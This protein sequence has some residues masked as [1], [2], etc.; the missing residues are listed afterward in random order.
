MRKKR[1][2]LLHLLQPVRRAL[3]GQLLSA[4][5]GTMAR[6]HARVAV[7]LLCGCLA[8]AVNAEAPDTRFQFDIPPLKVQL[9]LGVLAKQSG[10]QLLFSHKLVDSHKSSAVVGEFSVEGALQRLLK[11]TVLSGRVTERGVIVVSGGASK[12]NDGEIGKMNTKR[13]ILAM[14]VGGVLSGGAVGQETADREEVE[15]LLEEI[16]VTAAK[17][18]TALKNSAVAISVLSTDTIDKR[19][20]VTMNDYLATVPGASYIER[21][22]T[23]KRVILRGLST[24]PNDIQTVAGVYLG[25]QPLSSALDTFNINLV[26]IER[27]EVVKGPQGTLYGSSALGGVVRNIPKKVN[28]QNIEG[29]VKVD[30]SSQG[31]SDDYNHSLS[32]VVNVPIVE[33]TLGMRVVAYRAE[34]AGYVDIVAT[35]EAEGIALITGAD[36]I[37]KKDSN[38]STVDGFRTSFLWQPSDT[39]RASLTLGQQ[40]DDIDGSSNEILDENDYEVSYLN[41]EPAESVD[42]RYGNLLI[43]YDLGW[44][45][46]LSSS[47]VSN[48]E[49]SLVR[50]FFSTNADIF[51]GP[52]VAQGDKESDLKSQELRFNSN[53]D[54]AWQ[55]LGGVFYEEAELETK[56]ITSWVG[57]GMPNPFGLLGLPLNPLRPELLG[58]QLILV[59]YSQLAFFGEASYQINDQWLLTVGGRHFDYDREDTETFFNDAPFNTAPSN[60][61]VTNDISESGE[62]YKLNLAY[63]PSDDALIYAQWS[64]GF[65]LGRG[66]KLPPASLCDTDN[67]GELDFNT[68]GKITPRVESDTS[69]QLE[70]GVKLSLMEKRMEL[71]A[72]IFH[73]D[74][75]NLPIIID[76]DSPSCPVELGRITNNIGSASTQGIE[77]DMRYVLDAWLL[78]MSAS[79]LETEREDVRPPLFEGEPLVYAPKSNASIGLQYNFTVSG[80]DAFART[81]VSYVGEYESSTQALGLGSAGEYVDASIRAGITVDNW[82]LALY[83]ANITNNDDVRV[84]NDADALGQNSIGVRARPRRIGFTLSYNF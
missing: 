34:N 67:N 73:A 84:V 10:H 62:T 23:D 7:L 43:E 59:D 61:P 13:N 29:N 21:D 5:V 60:T 20:L 17:R 33:E 44:G 65:R 28:L 80:Y 75:D 74:W 41:E 83:G 58:D 11:G 14:V 16:V 77:V 52:V 37:E 68:G 42:I 71:N 76:P 53:F 78:N 31:E 22:A 4:Y 55:V 56:T 15:W 25:E 18:E 40:E 1:V 12:N 72:A 57:D 19:G 49:G 24:G 66:Q 27:V 26:D 38:S 79:Y 6:E 70:L 64:E 54:G 82:E 32:A 30:V 3:K 63:T 51:F 2:R 36:V 9:A 45:S 35:P 46:L 8:M 81:D 39:L 47:S 50:N 48:G 69:E